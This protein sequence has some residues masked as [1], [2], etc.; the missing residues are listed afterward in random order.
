[1][2]SPQGHGELGELGCCGVA[3]PRAQFIPGREGRPAAAAREKWV[4]K[5][6][7]MGF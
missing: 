7:L 1:M 6:G 4:W 3:S 5:D 2:T